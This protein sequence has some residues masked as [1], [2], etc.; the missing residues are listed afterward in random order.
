MNGSARLSVCLSVC[1][2]VTPFS[3]CFHHSIIMKFS[4]VI[5]NDRSGV[6]AKGRGQRS[7]VKVTE[8][9]TQLSRFRT[10]TPV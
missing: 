1:T 9:N 10:I 2:P 6:Y 4:G 5:A 8:I 7:K 3:L